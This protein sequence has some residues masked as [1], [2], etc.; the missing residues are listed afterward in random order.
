MRPPWD[1]ESPRL[2]TKG[3]THLL[4]PLSICCLHQKSFAGP[5]PLC[6]PSALLAEGLAQG[7]LKGG[8]PLPRQGK[9]SPPPVWRH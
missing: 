9:P 8:Q 7:V 1:A 3:K 4:R 2:V 5:G 6:S